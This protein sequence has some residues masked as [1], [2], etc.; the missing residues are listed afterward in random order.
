M[1]L[2]TLSEQEII[3]T[4][5]ALALLL[6]GAFL[7][8]TLF[9]RLKA[10]RV[11]GEILGGLLFGGTFLA[12]FFPGAMN[13]V[14]AAYPEEGKVLNIF[15]QLGL[16]FLMFLSGYNTKIEVDRK[17][18]KLI[19]CIFIGATILPMAGA[20][21]FIR[22]FQNSYIGTLGNEVAFA[23]VFTIGVAITSIPVISKIFFDMGIM[24][25][26]FSNTVL[27]ASTLQDLLLW[28]LLN[29]ATRIATTGEVRF[30]EM[31]AVVLITLGLFVVVKV[32]SDHAKTLEADVKPTYFYSISFVILLL[33]CAG[34]YKVGINIMYAAFLTGYV[35][36][37]FA[38]VDEKVKG[39]MDGLGNFAFS[40]FIPI[41]FALVGIQL[42]LL[43]DFSW[44]RFLAF[45]AIAFTLEGIGTLLLVQLTD[46]NRRS[47][48]N[49]AITMNARGGP[50]IVLATVAYSYDIISLEFFTVLILTTMLSSLIAGYWL[51]SQQKKDPEI[52][53]NLSK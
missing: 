36:K 21:P 38:G 9:E 2:P 49:F 39:L 18:S 35:V 26:R 23:L 44:L 32:V 22:L 40:F 20:V 43:N 4:L 50:G 6:A 1:H 25:T 17:N 12:H 30:L 46:L 42:N 47:K 48:I 31:L 14:F 13:A 5:V 27:T 51:R 29:A 7:V 34:L 24:N 45:F 28:I 16:I 10:P 52:F 19:T 15:Y 3:M 33:V 8:G 11:V 41:Y 37:A 53:M